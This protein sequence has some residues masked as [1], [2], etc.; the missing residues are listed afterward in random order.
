MWYSRTLL[1]F[2]LGAAL[3]GCAAVPGMAAVYPPQQ[4]L[5]SQAVQ[6]FL[7]N[8]AALLTQFPNG[9][10]QMI[11][12][13]RDLA[14]SDPKTLNALI[15]LLSKANPDQST[16]IGTALGQVA[17]M[18][19]STDQSYATDI[20][21]A[22]VTSR[23]DSAEVAFSAVVGGNIKLTAATGGIG[24]GG[25]EEPT[26]P[27]GGVGVGGPSS[28]LDLHTYATNIPDTFT[29]TTFGGG[30]PGCCSVSSSTP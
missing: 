27:G 20:Q 21:T 2:A 23:N 28:P 19:V 6:N 14:A 17:Q 4:A 15:G 5:S 30:G 18:A 16:A 8:P 9:G 3:I 24:G 25:G 29:T 13:V 11:A 1:R 26:V 7:A 22:I 10:P 12:A